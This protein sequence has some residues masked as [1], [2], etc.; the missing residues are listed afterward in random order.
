MN[1]KQLPGNCFPNVS[2][3]ALHQWNYKYIRTESYMLQVLSL[4]VYALMNS[5]KFVN[6]IP[7]SGP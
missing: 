1:Y 2:G 3:S 4:R 5:G 6:Y 7:Y